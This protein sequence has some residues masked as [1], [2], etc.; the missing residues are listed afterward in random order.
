MT[1]RAQEQGIHNDLPTP[2][3]KH[4]YH[5]ERRDVPKVA[6]WEEGDLWCVSGREESE[7][8]RRQQQSALGNRHRDVVRD[9]Q[10]TPATMT[11]DYTREKK[12][13]EV[14][15]S[16]QQL[17][18]TKRTPLPT[19]AQFHTY[20]TTPLKL[21]RVRACRRYTARLVSPHP[22]PLDKYGCLAAMVVPIV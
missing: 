12:R 11:T 20:T 2:L 17:F 15:V 16:R 22:F 13:Y 1:Q 3:R 7:G 9:C 18:L 5:K 4:L 8:A 6:A 19:H 10:R 21:V 14:G